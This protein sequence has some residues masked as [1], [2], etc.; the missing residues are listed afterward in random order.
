MCVVALGKEGQA[1]VGAGHALAPR[2]AVAR[3]QTGT[4]RELLVVGG[5]HP[6]VAVGAEDLVR[7]KAEAPDRSERAHRPPVD[8]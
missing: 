7:G 3:E 4:P 8:G 1:P 5:D 6:A 2:L